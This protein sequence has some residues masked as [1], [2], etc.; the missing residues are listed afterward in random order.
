MANTYTQLYIHCVFAVKFGVEYDERYIFQLPIEEG[1]PPTGQWEGLD[2][3][4][5]K[6]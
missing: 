6:L 2:I 1:L 3:L 5:T 4:S